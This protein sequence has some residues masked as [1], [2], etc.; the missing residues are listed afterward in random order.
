LQERKDFPYSTKDK[1]M[2]QKK[3][4]ILITE[5]DRERLSFLLSQ[6]IDDDF[7]KLRI[8]LKRAKAVS[9]KSIPHD[10]VT[11]NT[12]VRVQDVNTGDE[13]A[14]RVVFPRDENFR[15]GRI[16]VTRPLGAA[17]LGSRSG[18]EIIWGMVSARMK[19]TAKILSILYQPEQFG[20]FNL[21]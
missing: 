19:F 17:L 16:S 11:I 3:P 20:Q 1:A 8:R 13:R 10:I 6:H 21:K 2:K 18:N 4:N 7:P 9:N 5:Y 14:L 15:Q 12:K